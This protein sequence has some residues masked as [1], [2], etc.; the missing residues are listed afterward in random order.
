MSLRPPEGERSYHFPLT[1][2]ILNAPKS[3]YD[4][5]PYD[6]GLPACGAR[7]TGKRLGGPTQPEAF[8]ES[9][10]PSLFHNVVTFARVMLPEFV[11][12]SFTGPKSPV[13]RLPP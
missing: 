7:P 8:H 1:A 2:Q 13:A 11:I 5:S 3:G 4:G 10:K 6:R 9:L 12:V